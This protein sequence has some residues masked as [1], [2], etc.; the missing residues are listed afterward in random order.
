MSWGYVTT[1]AINYNF[2]FY[3]LQEH[4]SVSHEKASF[5]KYLRNYRF[6]SAEADLSVKN[7]VLTVVLKQRKNLNVTSLKILMYMAQLSLLLNKIY[8]LRVLYGCTYHM[9]ITYNI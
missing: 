3:R 8:V 9:C 4:L 1:F 7:Q 6:Y 2:P 5:N